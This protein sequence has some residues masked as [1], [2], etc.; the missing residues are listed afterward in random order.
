MV[1]DKHFEK[2]N[3]HRVSVGE[4]PGKKPLG[5]NRPRWKNIKM[6]FKEIGRDK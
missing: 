1:L 6:D 4:P 5:K 2:K 3:A